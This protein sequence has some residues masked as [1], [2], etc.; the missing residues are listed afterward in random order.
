MGLVHMPST[1]AWTHV[2]G[3]IIPQEATHFPL[4]PTESHC[5]TIMI[6]KEL[7]DSIQRGRGVFGH[8]WAPSMDL[9]PKL[10][11]HLLNFIVICGNPHAVGKQKAISRISAWKDKG[12]QSR[13]WVYLYL[14]VT[15]R[16]QLHKE[17]FGHNHCKAPAYLKKEVAGI[18]LLSH[19]TP[20]L[21]LSRK[22]SLDLPW[23]E[24][25]YTGKH[26]S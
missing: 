18:S 1:C 14:A 20:A 7:H 25:S 10:L 26:S 21:T 22:W 24:G 17:T 2:K 4:G 5:C 13:F 15:R 11:G 8:F 3:L 12:D 16:L 6:L 19:H 9:R 23:A